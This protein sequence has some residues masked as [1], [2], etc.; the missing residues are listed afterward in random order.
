[1]TPDPVHAVRP[2]DRRP[3]SAQRLTARILASC[4][5]SSAAA[6][7]RWRARR[8]A[9]LCYHGVA[10]EDEHVWNPDL[11]VSPAFLRS[12][13]EA[14]LAMGCTMLPLDE[15]VARLY[16]CTLPPRAVALTFDD[17]MYDFVAEAQPILRRFGAPA[18][19]YASTYYVDHQWPV[20]NPLC[21]YLLWKARGKSVDAHSV[22][23]THLSWDLRSPAGIQAAFESVLAFANARQLCGAD[24]DLLAQEIAHYLSV[25]DNHIRAR[26]IF[27]LMTP[28]ELRKAAHTPG[29][30]VELHTHRHRSPRSAPEFAQEIT[31]NTEL[32][33]RHT[34][35][36][37][38]HF[39]YPS[40]V[41]YPEQLPWLSDAGVISATTC[42]PGL[43]SPH[44]HPLLLPRIADHFALTTSEF[45]VRV[46]GAW[47]LLLRLAQ[48]MAPLD[49]VGHEPIQSR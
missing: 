13:I 17:G 26:R 11:F 46:S 22:L 38:R 37:P 20:F 1:M 42:H 3:R 40:G 30:T 48:P 28:D 34:G 33:A 43:A 21:A 47:A 27:H 39:C 45:E 29:I 6:R 2:T 4:G 8:L 41:W 32:I 49:G 10:L 12:R 25:D 5:V 35:R 9:I 7:T 36:L 14:L 18:T 23:G 19:V 16:E 44:S 31:E 24:K 15:A